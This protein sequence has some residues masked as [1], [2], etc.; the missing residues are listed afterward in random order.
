ML[1]ILNLYSLW[2]FNINILPFMPYFATNIL[3]LV[4]VYL[5]LEDTNSSLLQQQDHQILFKVIH[6]CVLLGMCKKFSSAFAL[7]FIFIC[8][9]NKIIKKIAHIYFLKKYDKKVMIA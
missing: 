2:N 5:F 9:V 1:F 7:S 4:S 3:P 8:L 6:V